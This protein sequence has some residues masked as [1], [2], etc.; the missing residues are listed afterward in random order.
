MKLEQ[1]K[2]LSY[3]SIYLQVKNSKFPNYPITRSI[4]FIQTFRIKFDCEA[5]LYRC[6]RCVCIQLLKK[7]S[8]EKVIIGANLTFG[9]TASAVLEKKKKSG[10]GDLHYLKGDPG[11]L[12]LESLLSRLSFFPPF[13]TRFSIVAACYYP[14]TSQIR[15]HFRVRLFFQR[16]FFIRGPLSLVTLVNEGSSV[17]IFTMRK[18]LRHDAKNLCSCICSLY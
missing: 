1:M 3:Y 6:F 5:A 14:V 7:N 2:V 11:E 10:N 4:L 17:F 18:K 8:K 9:R 13:S 15:T 16:E 12:L